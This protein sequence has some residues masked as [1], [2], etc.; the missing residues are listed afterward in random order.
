MLA[1]HP[2]SLSCV[3]RC[4]RLSGQDLLVLLAGLESPW[5]WQLL[6]PCS[7]CKAS[8]PPFSL[9]L[10]G[11]EL[12]FWYPPFHLCQASQALPL[13]PVAKGR[14]TLT[15]SSALSPATSQWYYFKRCFC[16]RPPRLL[17]VTLR[18]GQEQDF[19]GVSGVLISQVSAVS[20]TITPCVLLPVTLYRG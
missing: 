13:C 6:C 1:G 8:V 17:A 9:Q 20:R 12:G 18:T 3:E 15:A 5:R 14:G 16:F 4:F 10:S 2:T 7:L 19:K 11:M